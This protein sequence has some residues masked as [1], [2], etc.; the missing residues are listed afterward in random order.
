MNVR[1]L[2]WVA[3][4][5][6]AF[7]ATGVWGQ[8]QDQDT[9]AEVVVTGTRVAGR[10]ATETLSPVDLVR[11][12]ELSEQATFDLTDSLAKVSPSINTQRFPIADGTAFIR[13][14]SAA[15]PLAR[16][17][18]GPGERHAPAPLGAR[19]PAARA[20]GHG[21][22]GLAG[23]G[24]VAAFPSLA[25]DRVEILRDGASAQYG[26]DAIAGVV[27]L[28]LKTQPRR[29]DRSRRSSA[30]TPSRTASACPVAANMGLPLGADGF[31][32]L[33]GEY[34][35]A[36]ITSRGG[37]RPDAAAVGEIVGCARAAIRPRPALGRS[38]RRGAE[39]RGQRWACR[40]AATRSRSTASANYMDNT[41]MSGFFYRTPVLANAADQ[42]A[43][44]ARTTLQIDG[45]ADGLP[46]NATAGTGRQHHRPGPEPGRLPR[47][48][49]DQ[50]ERLRAAQPDLHRVPGRL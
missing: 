13:P 10:V 38:R 41:T 9:L 15:Q 5:G 37:A 23:R 6:A 2:K 24:L 29:R 46:D 22:P 16:S 20:T 40:S 4:A 28:I 8:E 3:T 44:P 39:V 12:E 47:G 48:Q 36:D 11:G 45:N 18:A 43:V 34:S 35:D 42:I 50:P 31:V 25:I 27:N 26:S 21:Q 49:R 33:T 1:T 19:E 7:A 30:S 32:S 17:H 14:V